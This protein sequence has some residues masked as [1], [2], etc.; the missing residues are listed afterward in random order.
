MFAQTSKLEIQTFFD[1][2]SKYKVKLM[3]V[4]FKKITDMPIAGKKILLRVDINS[5]IDVEKMQLSGEA[6]RI[7]AV[8]PTLKALKPAAVVLVAHQGRFGDEDCTTLK[9]HAD[10][11]NELMGGNVKFVDDTFGDKAVAAIKAVKPGEVLVLENVRKWEGE[12]KTKSVADAEKTPLIMNLKPLFDYFVNDAF[13]AAHRAHASLVGWPSLLAG[14]LVEKELEMVKKL[15]NPTR[16][17]VWVVGGAKAYDKFLAIKY[18]LENGSI[19]K[20]CVAGLTALLFLQAKGVDIG[21]ENKKAIEKNYAKAE[22][23]IKAV[24]AKFDAKIVLPVDGALDENGKR[25]EISLNEYAKENKETFDIG[26]KTQELFIKELKA[27][28]TI[29]AN[30]PPGMFE[31]VGVCDQGTNAVL[32]VM[33][34]M[35]DKGNTVIVGGGDF[36][37]A[38]ERHPSGSKFTISTGGGALLEILSGKKIPLLEALKTKMP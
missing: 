8:V 26:T 30:G 3:D 1:N 16:P 24:L 17:A 20:A 18:N 22:A 23:E 38:A 37:E 15:F 13:G 14:P 19:D 21:A 27:A 25:R 9:I 32:Q 34:E 35:A 10:R 11:L 12:E 2:R 5:N 29:V 6:P 4:V 31:K 7:K 33:G 28:K 36:G